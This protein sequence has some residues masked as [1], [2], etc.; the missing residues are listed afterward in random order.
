MQ[1][2]GDSD[3]GLKNIGIRSKKRDKFNAYIFMSQLDRELSLVDGKTQF[4]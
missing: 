4:F 3:F 1:V 2:V